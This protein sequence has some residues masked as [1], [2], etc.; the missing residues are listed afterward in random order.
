MAT[1]STFFAQQSLNTVVDPACQKGSASSSL[2]PSSPSTV[3]AKQDEAVSPSST[4]TKQEEATSPSLQEE[5]LPSLSSS[6]SS[7]VNN[8]QD[9]DSTTTTSSSAFTFSAPSS[10]FTLP[11]ITGLPQGLSASFFRQFITPCPPDNE[12][13][14]HMVQP[15]THHKRR[16]SLKVTFANEPIIQHMNP[17]EE[18]E[19]EEPEDDERQQEYLRMR[20][21]KR[22]ASFSNIELNREVAKKIRR[23]I[24]E[25]DEQTTDDI[26]GTQIHTSL[27]LDGNAMIDDSTSEVKFEFEFRGGQILQIRHGDITSEHVDV[28]V[29]EAT[30]NLRHQGG[31]AGTLAQRA[32]KSMQIDSDR[33]IRKHGPVPP[34]Q[35]AVTEVRGGGGGGLACQ[36]MIHAVGPIWRGGT[37]RE[38]N[39]LY[40]CMW[41]SLIWSS[42]LHAKSIAIPAIGSGFHNFQK[43]RCAYLLIDCIAKFMH[44]YP[45]SHLREIRVVSH[46]E[47]VTSALVFESI[48][49]FTAGCETSESERDIS[50]GEGEEEND[51]ELITPTTTTTTTTKDQQID[52]NNLKAR[53]PYIDPMWIQAWRRQSIA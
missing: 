37:C 49:K 22:A 26:L 39:E 53:S 38:D 35:V 7:I 18:D 40:D 32:G 52:Y 27:K 29:N 47:D 4:V 2:L 21:K 24:K 23:M 15:S 20:Q 9:D 8:K 10:T 33:W 28:I 14:G 31:I 50:E 41:N 13:G 25:E 36:W 11:E 44:K 48:G 17:I 5:S 3:V 16:S 43:E 12:Q 6:S 46:R 1:S 19:E 34:G 45:K 30:S 42:K 51:I